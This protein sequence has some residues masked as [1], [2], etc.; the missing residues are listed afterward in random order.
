MMKL[1]DAACSRK[2]ECMMMEEVLK[3]AYCWGEESWR[4]QSSNSVTEYVIPK[5]ID[6]QYCLVI[7][8][9]KRKKW[10]SEQKHMRKHTAEKP[11]KYYKTMTKKNHLTILIN[12]L[13]TLCK[14]TI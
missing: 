8:N 11:D 6:K 1:E 2:V 3:G 4:A 13:V 9:G 7:E 14:N 5:T 10:M 12:G